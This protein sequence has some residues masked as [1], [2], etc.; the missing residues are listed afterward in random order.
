M[1][2]AEHCSGAVEEIEIKNLF[3]QISK[4][5]PSWRL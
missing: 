3:L 4:P 5:D 1:G 2:I